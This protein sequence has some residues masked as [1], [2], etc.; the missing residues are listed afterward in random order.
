MI[1]CYWKNAKDFF[2]HTLWPSVSSSLHCEFIF[3]YFNSCLFCAY[4]LSVILAKLFY[5]NVFLAIFTLNFKQTQNI[6]TNTETA[7]D[8]KYNALVWLNYL[9]SLPSHRTSGI[10]RDDQS[11]WSWQFT[12]LL[13]QR[14]Q[15][16]K[17]HTFCC[18]DPS[19]DRQVRICPIQ[20]LKA[21]LNMFYCTRT[22]KQ[23]CLCTFLCCHF[24]F[25]NEWKYQKS[26]NVWIFKTSA[27]R[28][29]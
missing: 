22:K 18:W 9:F 15:V 25:L 11:S 13:H 3:A 21:V 4:F 20:N 17:C 29:L 14:P 23:T 5:F 8:C 28:R 24:L 1:V 26:E 6:K 16:A 12:S 2:S 27:K 10:F 19:A 7:P